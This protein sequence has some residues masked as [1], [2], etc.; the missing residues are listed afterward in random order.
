MSTELASDLNGQGWV[1]DGLVTTGRRILVGKTTLDLHS[2]LAWASDGLVGLR[3][4]ENRL[5]GLLSEAPCRVVHYQ[6]VFDALYGPRTCREAARIRLKAL[7][8]SL[9]KRLG[10][11]RTH[12][13]TAPGVGLVLYVRVDGTAD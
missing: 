7:V 6:V 2:G 13:C 5:L 3:P 4:Q 10:D 9:R 8:S 12:L 11:L 1:R